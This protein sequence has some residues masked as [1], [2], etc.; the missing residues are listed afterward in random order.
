MKKVIEF[1]QESRDEMTE[2]V[3]WSS[4]KSLQQTSVVVLVASLIF[5]LIVFAMDQA[6]QFGLGEIYKSFQ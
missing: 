1:L 5:A 6:F 2:H 4:F 3:T